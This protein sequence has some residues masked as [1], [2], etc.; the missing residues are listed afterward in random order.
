M[1]KS[2]ILLAFLTIFIILSCLCA[3]NDKLDLTTSISHLKCNV[4]ESQ[5][6]KHKILANYGFKE[7]QNSKDGKVGDK[8]Y[9]LSFK[10]LDHA[11]DNTTYSIS[12]TFNNVEHKCTFKLNPISHTL[13]ASVQVDNFNLNEFEITLRYGSNNDKIVMKSILPENT[14]PYTQALEHLIN[15]QADLLNL[16]IDQNGNFNGEIIMRVLVKDNHPYWYV[17]LCDTEGKLKALLIDGFD[18]KILAVRDIF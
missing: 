2:K 3:C 5:N 16:Y 7:K 11:L 1:K 18:G 8:I 10:F 14:I 12:L 4:Y 13:D 15:Q 6:T 17:G 9:L